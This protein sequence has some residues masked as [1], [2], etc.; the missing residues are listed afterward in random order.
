M[1]KRTGVIFFIIS[2][3]FLGVIPACVCAQKPDTLIKK[4]DSLQLK[5]ADSTSKQL[6]IV[7]PAAYEDTKLTPASY[8]ILLGSDLK[9]AFTKPFHMKKKDWLT[10]GG[11]V[12]LEVGLSFADKSIQSNALQ[13]RNDSKTLRDVSTY[14]TRFG[15]SYEVYTLIF[16]GGF[17]ALFNKPKML[18]TTF[19]ATQAY[20]TGEAVHQVANFFTGRQRPD[21][22]TSATS[23]PNPTFH[24]PFSSVRDVNGNRIASSFPSGH[25]TVAFAA[26]TVFAMEYRDKPLIPIIAY[27]AA[28]LIGIS[29]I[30]EN[31]HWF[32]DVVAGA[33]LGYFSG[34]QVVD[35]YHR[36]AK[37]K[38]P[39]QTKNTVAFNL[40]YRFGTVMPG[41]IYKFR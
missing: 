32:S 10:A 26:A 20:I 22:Y 39:S 1:Q 21:Y 19:L 2:I 24:G 18:N 40:D 17:G 34:K 23:L 13:M 35:N 37:L 8:F 36:Y 4:L 29:R 33:V 5:K 14:V 12:A 6:N 9:Q 27:T 41:M 30:T 3:F 15:G 16:M 28:S 31:R 11:F 7:A 25:T 38:A